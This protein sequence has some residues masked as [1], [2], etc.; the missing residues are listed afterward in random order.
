[1]NGYS[2]KLK[3][4]FGCILHARCEG[5]V[6]LDGEDLPQIYQ[7]KRCLGY[8]ENGMWLKGTLKNAK[9]LF[10]DEIHKIN[11]ELQELKMRIETLEDVTLKCGV[12]DMVH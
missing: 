10:E 7:C 8:G 3:C 9:L 1:M 4:E 11:T 2:D 6:L 5:I 12:S